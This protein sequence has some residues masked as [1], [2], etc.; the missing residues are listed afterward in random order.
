MFWRRKKSIPPAGNLTIISHSSP[1][2]SQYTHYTVLVSVNIC[3]C[4]AKS[5]FLL[6]CMCEVNTAAHWHVWGKNWHHEVPPNAIILYVVCVFQVRGGFLLETTV[7]TIATSSRTPAAGEPG[8]DCADPAT[9]R[10]FAR[11]ESNPLP[12][13]SID[14]SQLHQSRFGLLSQ[15]FMLIIVVGFLFSET[16]SEFWKQKWV[17]FLL[18][19]LFENNYFMLACSLIHSLSLT[20][21][22]TH[23]H[24]LSLSLSLSHTHTHTHTRV[25]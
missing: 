23:T 3:F 10:L 4:N 5:I 13:Q 17:F 9:T 14:T 16:L 7:T 11:R 2:L 20:H 18:H 15:A 21:T 1:E 22:H 8:R 6:H 12:Q 25:K 24:S 19:N